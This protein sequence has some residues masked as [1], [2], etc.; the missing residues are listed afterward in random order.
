MH[1]SLINIIFVHLHHVVW[2]PLFSSI[3]VKLYITNLFYLIMRAMFSKCLPK[4]INFFKG[5]S[6]LNF[7]RENYILRNIIYYV[8]SHVKIFSI[9]MWR[10][11]FFKGFFFF[12]MLAGYIDGEAWIILWKKSW[13]NW[14]WNGPSRFFFFF[15]YQVLLVDIHVRHHSNL[16]T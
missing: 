7:T 2:K 4:H 14:T 10:G 1:A 8:V 3:Y 11:N 13:K 12:L 16:I 15:W 9:L 5:M 6:N